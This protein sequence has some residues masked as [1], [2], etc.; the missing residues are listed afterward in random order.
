MNERHPAPPRGW[1]HAVEMAALWLLY[2]TAFWGQ[3]ARWLPSPFDQWH[4]LAYRAVGPWWH[5]WLGSRV[6]DTAALALYQ[7]AEAVVLAGC[8]P[9]LIARRMGHTLHAAGVR[10]PGRPSIGLNTAGIAVSVAVGLYLARVVPDPWGGP[11]V[12]MAGLLT[13]VPEHFL[14]FGVMGATLLAGGHDDTG[15]LVRPVG[16][17]ECFAIVATAAVFFLIHVGARHPAILWSA[18]PLG[19]VYAYSTVRT[20]SIWPAVLAHLSLNLVPIAWEAL[21]S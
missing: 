14:V 19:I 12:E 9:W 4:S 18:L 11:L 15:M 5:G 10:A 3:A 17:R 13:I 1:L 16:P 20:R 7:L 6:G 2:V 8:V 21:R